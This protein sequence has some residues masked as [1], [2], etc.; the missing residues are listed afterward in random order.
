MSAST[1]QGNTFVLSDHGGEALTHPLHIHF[2]ANLTSQE[3]SRL[4]TSDASRQPAYSFPALQDWLSK[5]LHSL[6]LQQ[7][8]SH[9]YHKHPYKLSEISIQAVDWFWRN[10]PGHEDKLGFMKI[11]S[12]IE[13]DPY[14]H[15]GEDKE[16][17][18]WVPGAVFLR[19]GSVAMLVT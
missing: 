4:L 15:D 2:P 6:G 11:Q 14:L 19:G 16:R 13:T 1:K 12:T 10:R 18:D 3:L 9:P 17:P 5:L 7:N 8:P